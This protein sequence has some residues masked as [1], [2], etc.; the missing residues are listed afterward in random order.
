MYNILVSNF[1]FGKASPEALNQLCLTANVSLNNSGKKYNEADLI[2][3]IANA[4]ILI[5][6]TEKI[7]NTVLEQAKNLQLI[8]RVGSGLDNIDLSYANNKKISISY[9]PDTPSKAVPEYTLSLILNLIKN[10]S[11]VDSRMH[12]KE[13]YRPMGKMLSS[14]KIGILGCG[15]IGSA[16]IELIHRI[17]PDT[18]IYYYDPF[19]VHVEHAIKSE[20][21]WLFAS[22]DLI[23]IHLPLNND[24][25]RIVDKSLLFSMRKGSYIVN[26]ARGNIV[27]EDALYK[28]LFSNHLAGAAVDVFA[29]EPYVGS[30]MQLENCILTSHIGSLTK[31]VRSIMEEQIVEDVLRFIDGK[32]LLRPV[33]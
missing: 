25:N 28:A 19:V 16:V 17:A 11:F 31:E 3:N 12:K 32:P 20:I 14:L 18:K 13:W 8:A 4:H 27:D 1:G 2:N 15:K 21:N 33:E 26:T 10:I 22:C 5:A 24:T 6:G 30:L 7:S 9:T 23:S 29:Q